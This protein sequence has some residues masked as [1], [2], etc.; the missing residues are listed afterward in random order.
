MTALAY[1]TDN[2]AIWSRSFEKVE[3]EVKRK[4]TRWEIHGE[5]V[6]EARLELLQPS[7]NGE[8]TK[9]PSD[10]TTMSHCEGATAFLAV[11]ATPIPTIVRTIMPSVGLFRLRRLWWLCSLPHSLCI[12]LVCLVI[13]KML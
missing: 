1:V 9:S 12:N 5:T 3:G 7:I 13:G 2:E 11:T 8:L 10:F 4:A 6:E